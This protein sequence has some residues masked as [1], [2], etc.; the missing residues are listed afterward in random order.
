MNFR[1]VFCFSG[2]AFI[3]TMLVIAL[4]LPLQNAYVVNLGNRLVPPSPIYL[5]GT[6]ELG[7]DLFSRFLAGSKYTI[8][9][10][11]MTTLLAGASGY[12]MGHGAR[13]APKWCGRLVSVLAYACFVVP[14]FLLTPRW[15]NRLLTTALCIVAFLPLFIIALI[16]VAVAKFTGWTTSLAL[17][18]L[19]GIGIAYVFYRDNS[20]QDVAALMASVFAWAV[21]LHGALDVLGLGVQPPGSSWGIMFVAQNK[22]WWPQVAAALSFLTAGAAAFSFSDMVAQKS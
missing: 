4:L 2:S 21:C 20:L 7:R 3:L 5:F 17:G 18:P 19:L 10:G 16:A 13:A 9:T 12:L 14:S 15:P 1:T 8:L 6:D 11:F 22:S